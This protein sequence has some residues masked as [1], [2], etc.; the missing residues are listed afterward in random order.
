M[1]LTPLLGINRMPKQ[2]SFL[3]FRLL[4]VPVIGSV[5]LMVFLLFFSLRTPC[6]LHQQVGLG[7]R[8]P[9]CTHRLL[10]IVRPRFWLLHDDLLDSLDVGDV[11]AE[12]IDDFDILYFW[13]NAPGIAETFH[14]ILEAFIALLL[15]DF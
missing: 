4:L 5:D 10:P 11:V 8:R 12:D 1:D 3:L 13:N 7:P 2:L 6:F 15:D 9:R 14:E